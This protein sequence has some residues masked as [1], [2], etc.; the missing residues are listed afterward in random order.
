M[1]LLNGRQL[2]GLPTTVFNAGTETI[3]LSL[4]MA[5]LAL[6]THPEVLRRAQEEIDGVV[7]EGRSPTF[8]DQNK[9][10]YITAMVD[11]VLRW[12]PVAPLSAPQ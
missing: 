1:E 5:M 12:R 2:S 3:Y 11:E 8:A 6:I 7:G 9:L 10:P 4:H